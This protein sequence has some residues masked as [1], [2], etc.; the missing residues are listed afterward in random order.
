M[1][2]I[3]EGTLKAI[4]F[5]QIISFVSLIGK[6]GILK[7]TRNSEETCVYFN[8][9]R[10]ISATSNQERFHSVH[11]SSPRSEK[12][13]VA[14]IIYDC[15]AWNDGH[16]S[17]RETSQ[18]P[19]DLVEIAIDLTTLILEGTRRIQ[20][21]HSFDKIFPDP[22]AVF[23]LEHPPE[24]LNLA[25]TLD[26]WKVLFLVNGRRTLEQICGE[27]DLDSV[28]VYRLLT[29]LYSNQILKQVPEEALDWAVLTTIPD[30]S[31]L[32][33]S[34]GIKLSYSDVLK[35]TLARLTLH[36][37]QEATKI[38]PLIEAEYYIGRQ[39]G[40]HIHLQDPGISSAHARIFRG[41]EGY[42]LEDLNS[43]NG[44]FVNGVRI[45]RKVLHD[46]DSIQ[47]GSTMLVYNIV[48]EVKQK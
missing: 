33:G 29:G 10:I 34:P 3:L 36:V 9:G 21:L 2:T 4:S 15:Y 16:F 32:I 30:D 18:F 25:L 42:V 43:R 28:A 39:P 35:V 1:E 5:P 17:F 45:D 24:S 37:P 47:I 41:P 40:T 27:S 12:M 46:R 6:S 7:S 8:Q 13:Q 48:Y 20:D 14:E 44:T 31:D 19:D 22:Q 11:L 26:E 23:R 38:F